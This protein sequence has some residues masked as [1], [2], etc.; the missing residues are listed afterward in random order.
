MYHTHLEL[1]CCCLSLK[2]V[3]DHLKLKIGEF[4]KMGTA[5]L[6]RESVSA[7]KNTVFT[8]GREVGVSQLL[9]QKV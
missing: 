9:M 1:S 2:P 7:L 4:V 6:N 8:S 3:R 5:V